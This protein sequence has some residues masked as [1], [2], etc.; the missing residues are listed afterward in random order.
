MAAI[1]Q[2]KLVAMIMLGV[3][4]LVGAYFGL[5]FGFVILI[6]LTLA[7][8]LACVAGTP[9]QS[10]AVSGALS[11]TITAAISLQGGYMIGLTGRDLFRQFVA[12]LNSVQSRRA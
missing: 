3:A 1:S 6:P 8:A 11:T 2:G 5:Y 4:C 10:E 7:L 9:V 12:R